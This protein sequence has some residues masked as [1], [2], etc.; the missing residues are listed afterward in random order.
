MLH[1]QPE[2]HGIVRSLDCFE[3]I[4]QRTN[5]PE[6]CSEGRE[7]AAIAPPCD[8]AIPKSGENYRNMRFLVHNCGTAAYKPGD[9]ETNNKYRMITFF[10]DLFKCAHN[11]HL[12][13]TFLQEV[14]K[15]K[16][17]CAFQWLEANAHKSYAK[18]TNIDGEGEVRP[19]LG[20]LASVHAF[21]RKEKSCG[22]KSGGSLSL[23]VSTRDSEIG[24]GIDTQPMH[25]Q[26]LNRSMLANRMKS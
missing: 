13:I 4:R 1:S 22:Q 18:Y 21:T 14:D 2:K 7:N 24:C 26:Q 16:V 17:E 10:T 12:D 5:C 8:E 9:S 6:Q 3:L 11:E 20:T 25:L 23:R 19:P 15:N